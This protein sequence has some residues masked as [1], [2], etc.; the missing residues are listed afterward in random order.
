[1]CGLLTFSLH[2]LCSSISHLFTSRLHLVF[3]STLKI[4][5]DL[6]IFASYYALLCICY[7]FSRLIGVFSVIWLSLFYKALSKRIR[8][9]LKTQLFLSV[10]KKICVHTRT[11]KWRFPKVPLWRSSSKSSVFGDRFI[12]YVWTE[13]QSV[14]KKLRF[15]KYLDTCGRGL[16]SLG[17]LF[18]FCF[19]L[20]KGQ[21]SKRYTLL[22][23]ENP[24]FHVF[25]TTATFSTVKGV[26]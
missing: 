15:Q 20:T 1:M 16:N 14:K 23:V 26:T 18:I 12:V 3:W 17:F 5:N 19:S 21:C 8:S 9:L 7:C 25:K 6:P 24:N 4:A 10:F 2:C 13:G 11:G 22:S